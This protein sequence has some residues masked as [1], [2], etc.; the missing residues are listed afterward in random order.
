LLDV[1]ASTASIVHLVLISIDR[2]VAAT[3]PAEYKTLKHR[4]RVYGA[5]VFAWMFSILLALP[6]GLKI[7]VNSKL[8]FCTFSE[9][10][11]H[12]NEEI[13]EK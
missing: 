13:L 3:R 2:L 6:L 12:K 7:V 9:L 11:K 5:I 4:K 1:S 8:T 10:W